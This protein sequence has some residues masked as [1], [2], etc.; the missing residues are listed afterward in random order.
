MFFPPDVTPPLYSYHSYNHQYEYYKNKNNNGTKLP[1]VWIL[2]VMFH[3]SNSI[4]MG[5]FFYLF[6]SVSRPKKPWAMGVTLYFLC[7]LL[8]D[9]SILILEPLETAS[10][11]RQIKGTQ[12]QYSSKPLKH[13]IVKRILVSLDTILLNRCQF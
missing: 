3:R 8:C 12:L 13:S 5:N 1:C 6:I 7:V 4:N 11:S 10:P 2:H 9:P